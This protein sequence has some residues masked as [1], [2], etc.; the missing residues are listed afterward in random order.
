MSLKDRM[1]DWLNRE[2]PA[3]RAQI[4]AQQAA[5]LEAY[6]E[7]LERQSIIDAARTSEEAKLTMEMDTDASRVQNPLRDPALN[8]LFDRMNRESGQRI[9]EFNQR[10]LLKGVKDPLRREEL[11]RLGLQTA[12]NYWVNLLE[13]PTIPL[14]AIRLGNQRLSEIRAQLNPPQDPNQKK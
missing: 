11:I 3:D 4:E 7:A 10:L 14:S 2:S 12:E 9:D 6:R 5:Q 8:N 13:Q 1:R